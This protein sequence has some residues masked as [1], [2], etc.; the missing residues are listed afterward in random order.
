MH[1]TSKDSSHD[2]H[3]HIL[4]SIL[5]ADGASELAKVGDSLVAEI[6]NVERTASGGI[7]VVIK[8]SVGEP[9]AKIEA[10]EEDETT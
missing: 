1:V 3:T 2:G 9:P 7:Q 10:V 4:T 5:E 6:A 8:V